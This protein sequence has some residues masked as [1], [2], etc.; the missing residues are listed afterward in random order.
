MV[1]ILSGWFIYFI[2]L[3]LFISTIFNVVFTKY[4]D[5]IFN[6]IS[7]LYDRLSSKIMS[8]KMTYSEQNE[9]TK[10]MNKIHDDDKKSINDINSEITSLTPEME[11]LIQL[12]IF[13]ENI[14]YM[15]K[16]MLSNEQMELDFELMN[17]MYNVLT[18]SPARS[19]RFFFKFLTLTL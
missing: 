12:C 19:R 1:L 4:L 17:E 16:L 6:P 8:N 15:K 10:N 13:L 5:H 3:I 11:D 2:I 9:N 7:R 14:T 18:K